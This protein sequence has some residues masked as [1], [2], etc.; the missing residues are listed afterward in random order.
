MVEYELIESL[1]DLEYFFLP[2]QKIEIIDDYENLNITRY[3]YIEGQSFEK[4]VDDKYSNITYIV[5]DQEGNKISQY[6][7]TDG[8]FMI[9]KIPDNMKVD[10][11]VK[12]N[13]NKY[14]GKYISDI[15]PQLDYQKSMNVYKIY[16]SMNQF[17]FKIKY[18]GDKNLLSVFSN[19]GS[20]EYDLKNDV[21]VVK[22]YVKPLTITL[23]DYVDNQLY[24]KEK[25]YN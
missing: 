25:T 6:E 15:T 11:I 10:L 9:D 4:T 7:S 12:D 22:D 5:V 19:N 3:S 21:Y 20:V 1:F 17:C 14:N 24:M 16:E 18:N 23:H 8:G 2:S 13:S